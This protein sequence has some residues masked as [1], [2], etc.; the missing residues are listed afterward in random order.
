MDDAHFMRKALALAERGRGRTSPNPMVGALVVDGEG[1]VAGRGAHRVA[2][3][4]HAEVIALADAGE[5]ARGATLY[6]TLEPCTHTGR[7]GPCAPLV[8]QAGIRRAVIAIEDPNPLVHGSGL[9]HLRERGLDVTV[10]VEREAAAR[11]NAAF[12]TA[13]H[14][15]R[16]HVILKAALSLDGWLA[17]ASGVRTHLTGAA[18]NRRVHRQRAEVDAVAVGSGT[19]LTDD[20]LLTPRGA[21]RARPLAR[22]VFD[23]RLRTPPSA[24]LLSTLDA[25]PV[26]IVT[27]E[28]TGAAAPASVT[29]LETAGARVLGL[30]ADDLGT[31]LRALKDIGLMSLVLEG[32]AALHRAA[33]DADIVDAIHV[34]ITPRALGPGGVEWIGAGRVAWEALHDRRAL[35]LDEDILVEGYVHRNH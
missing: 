27:S 34:Y 22:V 28:R 30:P 4:P 11:Q 1:V 17:A 16:P 19:V 14:H 23:R 31:A 12:L 32:G 13:M 33:L 35:W 5:R 8:V 26:I 21:Y 2:G 29:A 24:R 15:G 3:G 18:A 20:P 7:T 25:G 10:G 6:C 9:T